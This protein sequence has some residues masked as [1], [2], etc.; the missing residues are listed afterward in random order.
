MPISG[1]LRWFAAKFNTSAR[2]FAP[3]LSDVGTALNPAALKQSTSETPNAEILLRVCVKYLRD[4]SAMCSELSLLA[5]KDN[6][7]EFF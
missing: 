3:T 7:I 2:A 1:S 4:V 6:N 5:R